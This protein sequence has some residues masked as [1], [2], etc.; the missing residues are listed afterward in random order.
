MLNI[1][2]RDYW[3]LHLF[4]S[5]KVQVVVDYHLFPVLFYEYFDK[6]ISS[7]WMKEKNGYIKAMADTKGNRSQKSIVMN[8]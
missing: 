5:F 8:F 2:L 4:N 6:F 1:F 3:M 7:E